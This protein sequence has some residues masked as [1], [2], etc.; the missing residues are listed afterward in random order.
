MY[1][2]LTVKCIEIYWEHDFSF[3]R[4]QIKFIKITNI[5]TYFKNKKGGRETIF[6]QCFRLSQLKVKVKTAN[7]EA[8]IQKLQ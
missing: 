6:Q 8:W 2:I 3:R 7:S 5:M 4:I 1:L